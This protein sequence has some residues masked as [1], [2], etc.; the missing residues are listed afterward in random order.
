[1]RELHCTSEFISTCLAML[2]HKAFNLTHWW[3]WIFIARKKTENSEFNSIWIFLMIIFYFSISFISNFLTRIPEWWNS[4]LK[5]AMSKI[6]RPCTFW[7]NYFSHTCLSSCLQGFA[8]NRFNLWSWILVWLWRL[9]SL[10]FPRPFLSDPFNHVH[11][12][13]PQERRLV[14]IW[15]CKKADYVHFYPW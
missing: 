7:I 2:A 1:M 13:C 15:S 3:E 9:G 10:S 14:S 11:L 5:R 12:E 4:R 6:N 8:E